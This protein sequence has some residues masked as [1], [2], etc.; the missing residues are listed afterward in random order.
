[1]NTNQ[2]G[3]WGQALA[4]LFRDIVPVFC[5]LCLVRRSSVLLNYCCLELASLIPI[6]FILVRVYPSNSERY[7]EEKQCY[8]IL[9]LSVV[10]CA[11]CALDIGHLALAVYLLLP[12]HFVFVYLLQSYNTS[13]IS[14][15]YK[16]VVGS[17][18]S[19]PF[20]MHVGALLG[21]P[22]LR[23]ASRAQYIEVSYHNL[24]NINH[25]DTGRRLVFPRSSFHHAMFINCFVKVILIHR[26]HLHRGT[27]NLMSMMSIGSCDHRESGELEKRR[28]STRSVRVEADHFFG[29]ESK[30]GN[31]ESEVSKKIFSHA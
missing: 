7:R 24:K 19:P 16:L 10:L 2:S 15:A 4:D 23:I 26:F 3:Y 30:V 18:I 25:F 5:T 13:S 29:P 1:M 20:L 8:F 27:L 17:I 31:C 9:S 12:I 28:S 6:L 11:L 22:V 14:F 21:W